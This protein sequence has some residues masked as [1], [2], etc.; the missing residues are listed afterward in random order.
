MQRV[1]ENCNMST[2]GTCPTAN[3]TGNLIL[4][5]LRFSVAVLRE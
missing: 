1:A 2:N 3:K 4:D 5:L